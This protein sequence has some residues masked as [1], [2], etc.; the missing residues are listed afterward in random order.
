M[1][2]LTRRFA[3]AALAA[4]LLVAPSARATAPTPAEKAAVQDVVAR[5]S[6]L[7]ADYTGR[8]QASG[9]GTPAQRAA[10]AAMLRE[11]QGKVKAIDATRCPSDFR[12]AFAALIGT[13]DRAVEL[14]KRAQALESLPKEQAAVQG[15]MLMGQLREIQTEAVNAQV[16]FL[17]SA[18][19]CG[20]DVSA[21][22]S[23][24][25]AEAAARLGSESRPNPSSTKSPGTQRLV[26]RQADLEDAL[27]AAAETAS[28]RGASAASPGAC[29]AARASTSALSAAP[30]ARML[31]RYS[32]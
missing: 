17:R 27:T 4:A 18:K 6:A 20:A 28:R 12:A 29:P 13:Q 23:G 3:V 31:S 10:S 30:N 11:M 15:M 22:S 25:W 7:V 8:I 9:T 2:R 16:R 32:V 21:L 24:P 5:V 26:N 19:A 14:A 1:K